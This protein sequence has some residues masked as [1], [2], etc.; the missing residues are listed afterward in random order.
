MQLLG[1]FHRFSAILGFTDNF[2]FRVCTQK[3]VQPLADYVMII[4]NQ[5]SYR[6]LVSSYF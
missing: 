4:S 3:H 6:H 5:Y 2:E 1:Q